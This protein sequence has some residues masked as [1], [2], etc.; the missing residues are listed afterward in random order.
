M[1]WIA[2]SDTDLAP[3]RAGLG[4]II[5]R[6]TLMFEFATPL[7]GPVVLIDYHATAG[8]HRALSILIDPEAG[9]CLLHRQGAS[10]VR[11]VLSGPV[12]DQSGLARL[13]FA[14]DAPAR[15]WCL[16]YD[17]LD[18]GPARYA[19]GQNP[20]PLPRADAAAFCNSGA[21]MKRHAALRWNGVAAGMLDM[22]NRNWIGHTTPVATPRGIVQA[23]TLKQGD[24]VLTYGDQTHAISE[25]THCD[26]PTRGSFAPIRL[27]AP[28]F[29]ASHD[30]VVTE[31]QPVLLAGSELEYLFGDDEAVTPARHLIDGSSVLPENRRPAMGFVAITLNRPALID[32]D[33][34]MLASNAPAGTPRQ[35]ALPFRVLERYEAITLQS[36]RNRRSGRTA[37]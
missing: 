8:W 33:G 20:I 18:G 14:W 29:A 3:P 4:Q 13:W 2:L 22:T 5:D 26:L 32:C 28:Y 31:G 16:G 7:A 27:R 21:G 17:S 36:L 12:G 9:V 30:I 34:C 6:G 25:I 10:L 15:I 11:H 1:T 19:T 37:A 23:G 35:T 24:I